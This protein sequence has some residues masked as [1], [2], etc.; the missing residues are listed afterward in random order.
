MTVDERFSIPG[1]VDEGSPASAPLAPTLHQATP[2]GCGAR[3]APDLVGVDAL[4]AY[5]VAASAG[6]RLS[7]VVWETRV[8]PWGKILDQTPAPGSRVRQGSKLVVVVSGSPQVA[9]PDVHDLPLER[10]IE[11]LSCL[12][13]V[14]LAGSRRPTSSV[15]PGHVISTD[16]ATGAVAALGSVV[17]LAVARAPRRR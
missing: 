3:R 5:A 4:D 1:L 7:V 10:A 14:P 13:F 11:Q 17:V 15:P 16:P 12:G 8:G 9:V 2:R 6:V